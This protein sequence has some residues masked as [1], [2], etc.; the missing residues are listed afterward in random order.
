VETPRYAHNETR[1]QYDAKMILK[2]MRH[3][4]PPASFRVMGVTELDLYVPILKYVYGLAQIEGKCALISLCR[5]RPQFYA[6]PP[7]PD[8]FLKRALKTALHELGHTFGLTHCR[9]RRCAMYSSTR[10]EDTDYKSCEFCPT[11]QELLKWYIQKS[12]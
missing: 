11:C 8:L 7:N 12:A 3:Q 5:L 4:S 6:Q 9:N 10:I 1:G 2:K